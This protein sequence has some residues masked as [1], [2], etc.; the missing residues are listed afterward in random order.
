VVD[1][2]PGI[3]IGCDNVQGGRAATEHLLSQGRRAIAFVGTA[4][5]HTP[6]FFDRYRG[7]CQAL[8]SAKLRPEAEL[9]VDASDS[10]ELVGYRAMYELI[11]RGVKFDAVFAA[12]DLLAIGAIRALSDQGLRVPGDVAVVGFDDIPMA[13]FVNPP[14]TTVLQDTKRA[15]ELLV[16]NLLSQLR[17]EPVQSSMLP[18]KLVIR[19]SCGSASG[20]RAAPRVPA[21]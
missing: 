1:G 21:G 8:E 11:G 17:G 18:A 15:G 4:S 9:Q 19:R 16:G 5:T 12:S 6:E 7:H 14:L 20:V 3:S 2:Q 10:T 13:R